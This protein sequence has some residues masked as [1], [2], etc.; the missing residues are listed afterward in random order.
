MREA[1][2]TTVEAVARAI[3]NEQAPHSGMRVEPATTIFGTVTRSYQVF[4]DD[5]DMLERD[6]EMFRSKARAAIDA[7]LTSLSSAGMKVVTTTG[8]TEESG[9]LIERG[10]S[11]PSAPDYWGWSTGKESDDGPGLDWTRDHHEA[12]RFARKVDAERY[13]EDIGWNNVRICEHGWYGPRPGEHE[14]FKPDF[15]A[16]EC[17]KLCGIVKRSDGKNKPCKG[18]VGISLRTP[19][20]SGGG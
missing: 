9:W 8:P 6:R 16:Y 19:L 10:D 2:E 13:A 20:A 4:W 14:W 3:W 15:I 17:C 12:L 18:R 7:H 5:D 11:E 1:R